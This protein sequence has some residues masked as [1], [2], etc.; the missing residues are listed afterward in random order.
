MH[1]IATSF[2]TVTARSARSVMPGGN[3]NNRANNNADSGRA[4][5]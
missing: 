4:I 3:I 1:S 5:A 2:K